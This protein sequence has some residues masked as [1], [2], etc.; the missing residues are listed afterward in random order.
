MPEATSFDN[1]RI[2]SGSQSRAFEELSYQLLKAEVPSGSRAIR[3]GNPDGGVE[4]Y[5]F[6]GADQEWGWQAKYIKGIDALL[7][8]MTDSARRVTK[9]RPKLTR[10]TFVISTN[11]STGTEGRQRK[12]QRQIFNCRARLRDDPHDLIDRLAEL[13][14]LEAERIK[15]WTLA[16]VAAEPHGGGTSDD[17]Y[18]VARS[19]V[20]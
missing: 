7:T 10:L 4:W 11:L 15:L 3:T 19:L 2:W 16:R 12:S 5:A 9:E 20:P 18:S 1:L 14:G 17:L 13:L 6:G 8:A